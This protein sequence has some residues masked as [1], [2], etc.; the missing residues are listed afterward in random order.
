MSHSRATSTKEYSDGR[1]ERISHFRHIIDQAGV[2]HRV[3]AWN[4]DGAGTEDNPYIVLWIDDDARNPMLYSRV[5]KWTITA[6]AALSTLAVTLLSSVYAGGREGIVQEFL[7]VSLFVLGFALGPLLW[8]PLSE[9]FGRQILY[10]CTYGALT[11]FSAGAAGSKNI[12]T[13][14][15]LRFLAGA[16]GSS[17]LTGAVGVIA[18]L[19]VAKERG[20][21][22]S[23]F[24]AAPFLGPVLGPAIGGFIGETVGW[25]WIEGVMAIFTGMLAW[26]AQINGVLWL[27]GTFVI[28]ETYAP[29][30]QRRRAQK[31]SQMTGKIYRSRG[32]VDQGQ[33]TFRQVFRTSLLRPWLLLF[34]EP[35]VLLLS[36]YMAIIYG[37]LYMLLNAFPIVYQQG[38]GWSPGLGGLAFLGIA[39]GSFVAI[40]FAL[41]ENKR[42]GRMSDYHQGFAPPETRLPC[43]MLGGILVPIGFFW[44]AWTNYP[45]VH[46]LVPI[47]AGIP[48]GAGM[49]LIFLGL[50]LYL[51]D[52][53]TLFAASVLAANGVLRS[54]F[55]A[56]FPLFTDQMYDSLGTHW[57]SSIP[58]FLALACAPFQFLFYRYGAV[59]RSRCEYA[60]QS[61]KL[62]ES[63]QART[64]AVEQRNTS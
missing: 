20:P 28:P 59:I 11:V 56:T 1:R 34:R 54:L 60:E 23:L 44:F 61:Q 33:P 55:G 32:D 2:T 52:S 15:I 19:F 27:A 26:K 48:M 13:L 24:A 25:R 31:L 35:I 41:W 17:P 6:I 57:A 50:V 12:Q 47:A 62:M 8:A 45:S 64:P 7:G 43:V 49:I 22:M 18:D 14:L 4:F 53:Y 21:A 29:V 63:I 39:I 58:A 5:K 40:L 46:Y 10:V 38:R 9:I 3:E 36:I 51:I 30:L 37:T 16:V 42:Y